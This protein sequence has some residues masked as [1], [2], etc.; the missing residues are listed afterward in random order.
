M[1]NNKTERNILLDYLRGVA[2]LLTV[3]YHYTQRY[4]E[5]FPNLENW[6]F[7]A[8]Y[9][10]MA[11]A[12]FFMLS[13]YL[14][15]VKD[16]STTGVW[17]Y[18]RKRAI[19]LFPAYWVAIPLTFI[20]TYYW[21]PT[22]S[23]SIGSALIN[24]TMLESFIG[25]P[26]VDGAYWT[27]ANELIF[28]TFIAVVVIHFKKRDTLPV[29]GL[30]WIMVLLVFH[31]VESD[32]LFI[33]AIGKLIANKYG[34]MFVAGGCLA[35]FFH[36]NGER[37]MKIFSVLSLLISVLYQFL[38]FGWGY[39]IYYVVSISIIGCCVFAKEKGYTP[40]KTTSKLLYPLEYLSTISYPLYLLHQNIGYAVMEYT[41]KMI[42]DSEWI[43]LLPC[44]LVGLIAHI[45]H[46]YV[47]IPVSR[48][49][50]LKLNI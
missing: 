24:F 11:V 23:V 8:Q 38:T 31:F 27:L 29:F 9:G 43:V 40:G 45:V 4:T 49:L 48:K 47:E 30:G 13:G 35:Y 33:A 12:T 21:L 41:R 19:R 7:R 5:L 37:R 20:V 36:N 15:V 3:L 50:Q 46:K 22:R 44:C 10:Y 26:L 32:F 34:H 25:V 14:S 28:Y 42:T 39:T 1:N 17:T 16:E 2:C 6:A 18:I